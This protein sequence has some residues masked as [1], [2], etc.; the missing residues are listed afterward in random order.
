[1]CELEEPSDSS[2][3]AE[4]STGASRLGGPNVTVSTQASVG[5]SS[6]LPPGNVSSQTS[7]GGDS[8]VTRRGSGNPAP[9]EASSPDH[10]TVEGAQ[11]QKRHFLR[12]ALGEVK[13]ALSSTSKWKYDKFKRS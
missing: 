10:P 4:S 13:E 6:L 3:I 1:M 12:R 8:N 5:G 11:V 7:V 2:V 9:P